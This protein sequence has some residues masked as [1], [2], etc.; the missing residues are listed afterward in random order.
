MSTQS[1]VMAIVA[2]QADVEF[3]YHVLDRGDGVEPHLVLGSP[4]DAIVEFSKRAHS[5]SYL[6]IDIGERGPDILSEIDTIAEY[7][8]AGTRVVILGQIN[9]VG[10]YRELKERGVSEYFIKP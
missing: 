3:S 9:D 1:P 4:L 5:P 2:Y 8:E 6:L 10:F 7:C